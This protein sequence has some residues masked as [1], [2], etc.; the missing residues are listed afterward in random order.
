MTN[1]ILVK[2]LFIELQSVEMIAIFGYLLFFMLQSQFLIDGCLENELQF[3]TTYYG[4]TV[5]LMESSF[6]KVC[7]DKNLI[8]NE[9]FI[10][11]IFSPIV[12]KLPSLNDHLA[13]TFEEK[14]ANAVGSC[15]EDDWWLLFDELVVQLFCP[16]AEYYSSP[17]TAYELASVIAC[18]FLK[19]F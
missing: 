5:D 12:A 8:L 1:S 7:D 19:E 10:M 17:K 14:V 6:T 4:K 13:Y 9:D 3:W 18:I 2:H 15:A 16:T 11:N